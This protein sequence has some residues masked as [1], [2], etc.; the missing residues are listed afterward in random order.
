MNRREFLKIS[1]FTTTSLLTKACT[2]IPLDI[3]DSNLTP[4]HPIPVPESTD[5]FN[6]HPFIETH[7]EA[8]FIKP[9][10]VAI[11]TDWQA[12]LREGTEVAREIFIFGTKKGIS[13]APKIAIKANVTYTYGKGS[14]LEGMGI[15]TD[16]FFMEGMINGMKSL[17]FQSGNMHLHEGNWLKDSK[18]AS[19]LPNTG[20]IE[21]GER[22]G[23]HL[24]NFPSGRIIIELSLEQLE[25][26]TEILWKDCP[27]G[28][29]FRRIG[30]MAPYNQENTWLLNVAKFKAHRMG[31]S[32]CVK[33]LQGMCVTPYVHFCEGLEKTLKYPDHIL[34][35]FQPNFGEHIAELHSQHQKA[36]IPRWDRPGIDWNS[37]YGMEMWAQRTCDSLSITK[38][39]LS[40]VEGIYSRNGDGFLQGPGTGG[41][42][43]DFMTNILLFGKDPF[44]VDIIATWLAGHEPENFGLFHIAQERGLTNEVDP[45][46]IPV[47]HWGNGNPKLASLTELERTPLK[48]PYLC[49]D[50]L[51]QIESPYHMVDEDFP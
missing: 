26:D 3:P 40:I 10:Q 5:F 7:P 33:N 36:G 31:M 28:V 44:R 32:L 1:A 24:L 25:K 45:R 46:K 22:T 12:K 51:G 39:D 27:Q 50:Y 34:K 38:V 4:A 6:L 16:K 23:I 20:Y 47:F 2:R 37:G 48:T 30:Y 8:V 42:A 21:I 18:Y 35:D 9:T 15:V 41:T 29:V 11:K 17:G 13:I 43:E 14:T 19:D 49:R